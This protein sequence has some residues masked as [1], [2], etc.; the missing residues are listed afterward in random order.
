MVGNSFTLSRKK[1]ITYKR[2]ARSSTRMHD[3]YRER[4]K[5]VPNRVYEKEKL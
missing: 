3:D 4:Q 5:R 1:S 2:F